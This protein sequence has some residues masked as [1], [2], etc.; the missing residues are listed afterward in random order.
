MIGRRAVLTGCLAM[1]A[2]RPGAAQSPPVVGYLGFSTPQ[3]ERASLDELRRGLASVG[4]ED[5]R[6]VMILIRHAGGDMA[7]AEEFISEF[8]AARA[9]VVVVPGQA[10]AR[11][12]RRRSAVPIVS[13]GLPPSD[14]ELF[15]SLARPGGTVTGFSDYSEQLAAKRVEILK[16]SIAGLSLIGVMHNSID[17]TYQRWGDHTREQAMKQG[18]AAVSLPLTS[19]SGAAVHELIDKLPAGAPRAII[20]VR[21]FLT[22]AMRAEAT[23]A[24]L[25]RGI[26]LCG[27]Q[28]AW[29]EGG[30]LM[31]YGPDFPDLF[32]RAAL[33]VDRILKGE[34]PGE[35]PIQLPTKIDFAI[36][37]DT[38]R[39]LQLALPSAILLQADRVIE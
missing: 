23:A 25:A 38:A 8:I 24:A 6:D 1:A 39:R 17:P 16:E 14:P 27:A 10:A 4:R 32:R 30:A 31:S 13:M 19:T 28:A 18:I 5:G 11:A 37:L 20:V 29:A 2:I 12:L 36:N 35:L 15:V 21:D 33:Y 9:A 26:A 34:K 7:R 22:S 3:A